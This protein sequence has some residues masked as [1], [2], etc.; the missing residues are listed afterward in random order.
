MHI[1][2]NYAEVSKNVMFHA[3]TIAYIHIF[4]IS[5]GILAIANNFYD[6]A[7]YND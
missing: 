2:N 5:K 7:N 3:V 1:K 6:V 4:Q